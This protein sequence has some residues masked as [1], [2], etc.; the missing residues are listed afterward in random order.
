MIK[1][2]N[3]QIAETFVELSTPL[4]ADACLRLQAPLRLAPPTIR[5]LLPQSRLAGRVLPARHYGSVDIFLEAMGAAQRGDVLVAD[6]GGRW[7]ESCVGDLIVL[8]AQ[9][10]GLAGIIIWGAHRDTADLI[11]IGLPVFSCGTCAAGPQRLDPRHP[12]ALT[13]AQS[14][15]WTV[16]ND[17]WVFADADG[18]LFIA[19]G[20]IEEVVHVAQSIR[21]IERAQAEAVQAGK[22][23]R[24]QLRFDEYL[25]CRAADPSLS[26]REHLRR[27]G[28]AVEV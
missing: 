14:S 2:R 15:E 8:E 17:D 19:G 20:R 24:H 1:M 16:G 10:C 27:I 4:L 23:L 9:A 12:Q 3:E 28:G 13:S 22:L 6:N 5:P 25:K 18:V 7:D 11:R 26:F 21:R